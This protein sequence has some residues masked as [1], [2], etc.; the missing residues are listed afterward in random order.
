MVCF[1][2]HTGAR[3]SEL[4]RVEIADIDFEDKAVLINEKK[5]ARG[6]RTP[7]R[8]PLAPVLAG[9]LKVAVHTPK[10]DVQ[11]T[12]SDE[13]HHN[14][15]SI[16]RLGQWATELFMFSRVDSNRRNRIGIT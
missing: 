3:R 1:A 9:V 5:R 14:F 6:K 15:R 8:V 4:L 16:L 2:A 7:R 11:C 13:E 10:A 12:S